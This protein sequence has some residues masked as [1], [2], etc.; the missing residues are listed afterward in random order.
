MC[1]AAPHG[2]LIITGSTLPG[3][4]DEP[5]CIC[6]SLIS[7]K[8]QRGPEACCSRGKSLTQ[9]SSRRT[10]ARRKAVG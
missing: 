1:G 7:L 4:I 8:P 6:G 2:D 9:L 3:M 10:G 5:A